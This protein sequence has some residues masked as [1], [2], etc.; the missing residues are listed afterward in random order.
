MEVKSSQ[1]F[2]TS[3]RKIP[4]DPQPR[5][6]VPKIEI[7]KTG[8]IKMKLERDTKHKDKMKRY[9]AKIQKVSKEHDK[10][11]NDLKALNR[12]NKRLQI[13]TEHL[14]KKIKLLERCK[15]KRTLNF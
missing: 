7:I 12:G 2:D 11:I 4:I 9:E 14:K 15:K 5:E 13:G 8:D 3:S 6:I 10:T 1:R